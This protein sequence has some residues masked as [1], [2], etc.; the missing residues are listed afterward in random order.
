MTQRLSMLLQ[1]RID[2]TNI[3]MGATNGQPILQNIELYLQ[4]FSKIDQRHF[5]FFRS[6]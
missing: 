2:R 1:S 5:R 6:I 3:Q 4:T